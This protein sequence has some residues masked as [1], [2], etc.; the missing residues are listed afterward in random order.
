MA[1]MDIRF[2]H[3]TT[4]PVHKL[5]WT[6]P[7]SAGGRLGPQLLPQYINSTEQDRIQLVG[8]L[9]PPL[10]PQYTNSTEQGRI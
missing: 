4:P 3:T 1:A 10:H 2:V 7:D 8:G 6:G 9:G 5:N